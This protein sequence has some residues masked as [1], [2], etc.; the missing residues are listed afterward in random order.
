[1][2][3]HKMRGK[4]NCVLLVIIAQLMLIIASG[5]VC[6]EAVQV[7]ELVQNRDRYTNRLVEV[8]GV[9][10]RWIE[11]AEKD[12]A[13]FYV[14]KDNFGDSID[15]QTIEQNPP[16]GTRCRVSGLL[17]EG[18]RKDYVYIQC[19]SITLF[20]R[21]LASP[22]VKS[23]DKR[24]AVESD[25]TYSPSFFEKVKGLTNVYTIL[26]GLVLVALIIA[27]VVILL[28]RESGNQMPMESPIMSPDDAKT[29]TIDLE[30]NVVSGPDIDDKTQKLMV[31]YFEVTDGTEG[32]KGQRLFVPG[33]I[34]K[35]GR[36]ESG[37][38]KSKG[39]ITFPSD[40]GTVSRHQADLI[41]EGGNY[42]LVNHAHI[43]STVVN[44]KPLG[45]EKRV[46]IKDGDRISIGDIELTFHTSK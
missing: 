36:E 43:N 35:I 2:T 6:A 25:R 32:I 22:Q 1:M 45:E 12:K 34:T 33:L 19:R 46:R 10:E 24:Q 15:V 42:V 13:G 31:G 38:D 29:I 18:S 21:E 20:E 7:K 44:G 5:V 26:V 9:V 39:W 14:L 41:F 16:V 11:K 23:A 28:K 30:G 4:I 8:E 27:V 17:S 37:K 40:H 3:I